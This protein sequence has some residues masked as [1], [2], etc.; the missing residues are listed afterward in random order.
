[1]NEIN[2][3]HSIALSK[4][5]SKLDSMTKR[6]VTLE[7]KL[8]KESETVFYWYQKHQLLFDQ[9]KVEKKT[10]VK[11]ERKMKK[12]WVGVVDKVKERKAREK[13]LRMTAQQREEKEREMRREQR[14]DFEQKIGD[15][16]AKHRPHHEAS[17][18]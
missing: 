12:D 16:E 9:L 2:R 6:K 4:W 15:I 3:V 7:K 10:A 11:K 5:R 17:G 14:I 13:K 1:M 18:V 8:L